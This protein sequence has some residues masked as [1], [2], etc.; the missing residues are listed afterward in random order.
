MDS[1]ITLSGAQLV[2]EHLAALEILIRNLQMQVDV[3][4]E[5]N[6]FLDVVDRAD[7]FDDNQ[8]HEYSGAGWPPG[9]GGPTTYPTPYAYP[10]CVEK[11]DPQTVAYG[12][13][14]NFRFKQTGARTGVITNL[15]K[16]I[17]YAG[18]GVDS[19]SVTAWPSS[20]IITSGML[21]DAG[22]TYFFITIDFPGPTYTWGY[23][24]TG[25]ANGDGDTE[26][27][28]I[29]EITHTAELI[30][31]YTQHQ[32]GDIHITRSA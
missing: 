10:T 25:F 29:F 22:T 15:Q 20:N 11:P 18:V 13:D 5:N 23:N 17:W 14:F 1:G 24:K 30:T 31:D 2:R 28:P 4:A 3:N 26:I 12:I 16:V 8:I 7:N 6:A 27:W 21:A 9:A 32:C 19:S